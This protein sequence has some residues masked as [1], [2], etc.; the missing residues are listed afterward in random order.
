MPLRYKHTKVGLFMEVLSHIGIYLGTVNVI[1]FLLMALDKSRARRS[2]WRIPEAT[3]FLFAIFGGCIG[4][5]IGMN[6]FRHKTQKPAFYIG[7]PIILTIQIVIVLYF[8]FLSPF[9]FKIM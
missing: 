3:L 2:K 4:T 5:I 6:L 1:G 8:L 9:A 7:L